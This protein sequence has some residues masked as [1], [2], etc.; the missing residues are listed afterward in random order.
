VYAILMLT[1][2][3]TS[4]SCDD[5]LPVYGQPDD[6]FEAA[7]LGVIPDSVSFYDDG[8]G[9]RSRYPTI[10]MLY[11]IKNIYEETMQLQIAAE[12]TVEI[13]L[14]NRPE[15]NSISAVTNAN[16]LPSAAFDAV[17]GLLTL[18][19]GQSI[20]MEVYVNPRLTAGLFMHKYLAVDRI[21][22]DWTG[23]IVYWY[24]KPFLLQSRLTMHIAAALKGI[25]V[26]GESV[27]V[28]T[29]LLPLA[30]RSTVPAEPYDDVR[31]IL[32]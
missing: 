8:L 22:F 32:R 12:G 14:P 26:K 30:A 27:M 29:G 6:I 3:A 13:W 15:L 4:F 2:A 21:E 25:S 1:T 28:M 18:H 24:Y 23:R 17:T 5:P 19:S 31:R 7:L 16:I 9:D 10:R 20:F 11:R